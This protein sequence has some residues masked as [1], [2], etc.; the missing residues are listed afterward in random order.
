MR[1][2]PVA[3]RQRMGNHQGPHRQNHPFS[4]MHHMGNPTHV[5]VGRGKV[6]IAAIRPACD[7][8]AFASHLQGGRQTSASE[9]A[10]GPGSPRPRQLTHRAFISRLS[11]RTRADLFQLL[12]ARRLAAPPGSFARIANDSTDSPALP[13]GRARF[14]LVTHSVASHLQGDGRRAQARMQG[15]AATTRH[16][17]R[18]PSRGP[19]HQRV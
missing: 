3:Y 19:H 8:T 2:L 10:G 11:A 14:G 13:K 4:E 6:R 7:H 12:Q 5:R 16:G 18:H 1:S 15:D 9:D 17:R